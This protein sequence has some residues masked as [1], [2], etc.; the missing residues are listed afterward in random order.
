[1]EQTV[2]AQAELDDFADKGRAA[3]EFNARPTMPAH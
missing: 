3:F 2:D 1:M